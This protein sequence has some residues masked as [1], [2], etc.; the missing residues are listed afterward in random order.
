MCCQ[1]FNQWIFNQCVVSYSTEGFSIN[2]LSVIQSRDF[3]SM[4]CQLFN[5]GIYLNGCVL[6]TSKIFFL[7]QT[8]VKDTQTF[9]ELKS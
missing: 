6:T 3:Q 2:V 9:E 8:V 4:C 5:Q 7:L 1:L